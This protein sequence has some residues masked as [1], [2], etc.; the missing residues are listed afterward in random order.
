MD[1]L[2]DLNMDSMAISAS[3][4]A[5][6]SRLGARVAELRKARDITQVEMAETL[7][8]SQQTINS[9][10]VGRRRIPVSALPAL[11]RSLGVSLEELLG[12]DLGGVKKRGPTPKLQQQIERIMELP[13][14]QQR[15][16]M[17]MLDTVLA[18][19]GR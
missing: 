17:Q 11:A 3:E 18:Q 12:E 2:N 1:L 5:F 19:Q 4:R 13:R 16:V 8:V 10:E 9:Y 7:G 14:S 15:F 6:F